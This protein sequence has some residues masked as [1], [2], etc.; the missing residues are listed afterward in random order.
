M[1]CATSSRNQTPTLTPVGCGDVCRPALTCAGGGG[2]G[3]GVVVLGIVVSRHRRCVCV[4][5][6]VGVV[7]VIIG[8]RRRHTVDLVIGRGGAPM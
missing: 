4:G 5:V 2:G 8:R 1:R 3:G 7:G 6:V